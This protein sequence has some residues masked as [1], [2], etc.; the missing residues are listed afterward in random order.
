MSSTQPAGIGM[1]AWT[2][3]DTPV[4]RPVGDLKSSVFAVNCTGAACAARVTT[5][6]PV[7]LGSVQSL[8]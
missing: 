7:G 2:V 5:T 3:P 6:L 8:K 4:K 1:A